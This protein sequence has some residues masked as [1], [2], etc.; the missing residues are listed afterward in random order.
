MEIR[1]ELLRILHLM[2]SE[3]KDFQLE[4]LL[5][6]F[7]IDI[8]SQLEDLQNK[9]KEL[10]DNLQTLEFVRNELLNKKDSE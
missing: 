7:E 4:L 3:D 1:N 10:N 5:E 9:E 2:K 8:K 6:R